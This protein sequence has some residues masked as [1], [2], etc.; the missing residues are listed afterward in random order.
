MCKQLL[1][2]SNSDDLCIEMCTHTL[3]RCERRFVNK[4]MDNAFSLSGDSGD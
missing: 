3:F 4:K 1:V 2:N